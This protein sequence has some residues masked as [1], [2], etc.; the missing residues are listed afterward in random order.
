MSC[1]SSGTS[2]TESRMMRRTIRTFQAIQGTKVYGKQGHNGKRY[3]D[4]RTEGATPQARTYIPGNVPAEPIF[5]DQI[6]SYPHECQCKWDPVYD[7]EGVK[8][9][10]L[11]LRHMACPARSAGFHN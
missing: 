5:I 1:Q 10:Q 9:W 3:D 6:P 2:T 8:T 4:V 7:S 11:K